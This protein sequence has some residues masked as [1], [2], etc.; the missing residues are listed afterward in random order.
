MRQVSKAAALYVTLFIVLSMPF[1]L[2]LLPQNFNGTEFS[3]YNSNWDGLSEFRSL[4][5]EHSGYQIKTLI[6][7]ANIL[8]RLNESIG[9]DAGSLVIMG[10]KIHYD[11][12]ESLAIM[13]YAAKGGR[14]LIADD[15]GTANDILNSF[16][17]LIGILSNTVL[18]GT[19]ANLFGIDTGSSTSA[20]ANRTNPFPIVGLAINKSVLVDTQNFYKSPVQPVFSPPPTQSL[21]GQSVTALAPWLTDMVANDVQQVIGNYASIISMKVQYPSEY[22]NN[23]DP[24]STKV[25]NAT[26]YESLTSKDAR[27]SLT[28]TTFGNYW[29]P[30]DQFSGLGQLNVASIDV[31]LNV[32]FKLSALY[33]SQKSWLEGNVTAA[34][35]VDN[36]KPD[37]SEWGNVEFPVAIEFPMGTS[38]SAG[39]LIIVSDPSIF[40]NRYLSK[41]VLPGEQ[42]PNFN[43]TDF[44]NRQFASNIIDI[45]TKDRPNGVIYFDEGHL[46]QS[47]LSPTM[48]I[49][50]YFR[51]L[52][53]MSMVPFIA[54]FLPFLVYGLARSLAPKG[55]YGSALLK[56]KAENYYGKSYFAYKMRWF[57]ENRHF[58]RGLELIY[59]R[60]KRDLMKRYKMDEWDVK[61]AV[62]HLNRDYGNLR[63]NLQSK[64]IEIETVLNQNIMIEEQRFMD[65][66]LVCQEITNHVKL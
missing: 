47:L 66:Y 16:S 59:R 20:C 62:S 30:F 28:P 55:K 56:T 8:N 37:S 27:C 60:I 33:S 14:V 11:P 25:W 50:T 45:L 40:I 64:M 13:L 58:N 48:Y 7:S 63:K 31:S 51:L 18:N 22:V 44:D 23:S 49:G 24:T 21:Q 29:V 53:F 26:E 57:L 42:D 12:F 61:I 34:R 65:L 39:S 1:A 4:V 35:N 52:D 10:P 32:T 46:E 15:F 54:P 43:P 17:Q 19:S 9:A 36:I 3:I 2:S 5:S 6:G 41:T 38:A